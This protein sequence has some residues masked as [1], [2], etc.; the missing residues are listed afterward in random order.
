[1][2]GDDVAT[3]LGLALQ[4]L[5]F[6]LEVGAIGGSH[7]QPHFVHPG[8]VQLVQLVQLGVDLRAGGPAGLDL[9]ILGLLFG[10]RILL[11]GVR[12][13]LVVVFFLG[14]FLVSV[15]DPLCVKG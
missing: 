8:V 12:E 14:T 15:V 2:D 9:L 4:V 7:D 3:L 11:F 5:D 1:V 6:A 13:G 10:G